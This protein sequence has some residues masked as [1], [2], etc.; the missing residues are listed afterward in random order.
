[1]VCLPVRVI[2]HSQKLVDYLRVQADKPG[3]NYYLYLMS[4]ARNYNASLKLR[5][6]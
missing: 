3:Y 2:I 1:M 6:T 5:K 4:R